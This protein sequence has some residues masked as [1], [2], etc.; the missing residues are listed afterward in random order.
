[1]TLPAC[2]DQQV[3]RQVFRQ[4]S[5]TSC[6][7]MVCALERLEIEPGDD[8]ARR[9]VVCVVH[10]LKSN[11]LLF[12]LGRLAERAGTLEERLEEEALPWEGRRMDALRALGC[13]LEQAV[14]RALSGGEE[15]SPEEEA[16]FDAALG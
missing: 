8:R 4:E 1:M 15:L 13:A 16:L 7:Q 12:E 9:C 5:A 6:R 14:S 3:L 10:S 11:A 2:I